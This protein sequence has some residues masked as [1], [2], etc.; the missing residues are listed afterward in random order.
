MVLL[1]YLCAGDDRKLQMARQMYENKTI[2]VGNT[3]KSLGIPRSTFSKYV[4]NDV[5]K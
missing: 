5:R 2:P 4:K 1:R 3:Y